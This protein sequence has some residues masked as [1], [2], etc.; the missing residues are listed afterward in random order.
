MCRVPDQNHPLFIFN[1]LR[2]SRILRQPLIW[3]P[4]LLGSSRHAAAARPSVPGLALTIL[5]LLLWHFGKGDGSAV[6]L[7]AGLAR[8]DSPGTGSLRLPRGG[9]R[10]CVRSRKGVSSPKRGVPSFLVSPASCAQVSGARA[11]RLLI[12]CWL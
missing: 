8:A 9:V 1:E 6:L 2:L 7:R 5:S 4:T 12:N 10:A 11:V 3:G